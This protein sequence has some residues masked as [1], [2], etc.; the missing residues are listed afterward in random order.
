VVFWIMMGSL[1]VLITARYAPAI[2][3][4]R[5]ARRLRALEG[6]ALEGEDATWWDGRTDVYRYDRHGWGGWWP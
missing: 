6:R 5:R 3:D 2:P 4:R 1:A